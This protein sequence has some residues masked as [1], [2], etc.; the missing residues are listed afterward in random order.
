MN[1]GGRHRWRAAA[2]NDDLSD[3]RGVWAL[4]RHHVFMAT[5]LWRILRAARAPITTKML[6]Y[7]RCY[8]ISHTPVLRAYAPRLLHHAAVLKSWRAAHCCARQ[9]RAARPRGIAQACA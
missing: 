3:E 1:D 5:T 7:H 9:Q 4:C 6:F 2:W 8:T